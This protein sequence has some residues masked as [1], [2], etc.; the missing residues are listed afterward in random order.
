MVK[1]DEKD[2]KILEV[3]KYHA[4][5][6][7][8]QI[9]KKLVL[10]IT[11]VHNRIRKLRKEKIIKKYTVELD[12]EKLDKN[13]LVYI[14]ISANIPLLKAKK[15]TQY[16][17]AKTLKR[18]DFVERVDIVAG[19]TDLITLVRVKDVAEFDKVLLSKLQ[20]LEGID[21]TQSLIVLHR[22]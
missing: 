5:Y 4:E 13:F 22:G 11:T 8:R 16:D 9:A 17:L 3:L 15:K 18:F 12:F 2:R 10:P 20:G 1:I 7:T 19:G 21:R 14:L 6:T